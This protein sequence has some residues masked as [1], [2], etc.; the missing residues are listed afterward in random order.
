VKFQFFQQFFLLT[1]VS[2]TEYSYINDIGLLKI[3]FH[4]VYVIYILKTKQAFSEPEFPYFFKRI[5]FE[6]QGICME[7]QL[8]AKM[9]KN[10]ILYSY[11][12]KRMERHDKYIW[13]GV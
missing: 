5:T 3:F 9:F 6:G 8:R 12:I 2:E 11:G 10:L 1:E 7:T 13:N 4:H